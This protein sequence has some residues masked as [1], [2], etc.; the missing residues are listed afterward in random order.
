MVTPKH[1]PAAIETPHAFGGV[2]RGAAVGKVTQIVHL[3]IGA[4]DS[5]MPLDNLLLHLLN[6]NERPV[7][8]PNDVSVSQVVVGCKPDLT[9]FPALPDSLMLKVT[10]RICY[11]A[12]C[13]LLACP[14]CRATRVRSGPRSPDSLAAQLRWIP[15]T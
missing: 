1:D 13:Q 2:F 5:V 3:V 8:E 7:A 10:H 4:N 9:Q 14:R 11:A 15:Y 12:R 6:V